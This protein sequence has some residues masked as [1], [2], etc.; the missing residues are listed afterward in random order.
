MENTQ[1][2]YRI[3]IMTYYYI[4]ECMV[5]V[6]VLFINLFAV[7]GMYQ[8]HVITANDMQYIFL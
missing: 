6:Q 3:S 1:F 7:T 5:Q 2:P 4:E 8:K